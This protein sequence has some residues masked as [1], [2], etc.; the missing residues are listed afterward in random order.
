MTDPFRV[1]NDM[2]PLA[3]LPVVDNI[4]DNTLLVIIIFLR[5]QDILGAVGDTAPERD[6]TGIS[7]HHFDNAAAFMGGRGI[8]HLING[9]HRRIDGRIKTD[10]IICAGDIQIDRS[11]NSDR[12]DSMARQCLRPAVGTVTADHHH[13]VDP[14]LFAHLRT[15]CLP[16][17]I[18]EFRAAGRSQ[19]RTAALDRI[20]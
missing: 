12:I 11:R 13:A 10:R 17:L 8:S 4:V 19:D 16:F 7:A 15:L 18:L 5:D 2:M 20:R 1:D 9:L 6:I 14:V 3:V